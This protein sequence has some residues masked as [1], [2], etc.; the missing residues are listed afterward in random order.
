MK[1]SKRE[2]SRV[3]ASW[4]VFMCT[5]EGLIEGKVQNV[6]LGGALIHC[7]KVPKPDEALELNIAIPGYFF[8]ISARVKRVRLATHERDKASRSYAL[9]VR[10]LEIRKEDWRFFCKAVEC[11]ART[12]DLRPTAEESSSTA[13]S[14]RGV[15]KSME[16]LSA[17]LKRPF[18]GLLEEAMQDLVKKY[19]KAPSTN[20]SG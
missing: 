13:A 15:V 18:G 4:P 1:Q 14:E 16:Q 6:S 20:I 2:Y 10:F 5:A 9:A 19:D 7:R 17:D 11:Q 3:E 12:Q 8:P